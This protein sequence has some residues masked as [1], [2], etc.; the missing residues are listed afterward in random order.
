MT[1]Y[2]EIFTWKVDLCIFSLNSLVKKKDY[3]S[4]FHVKISVCIFF[5][6]GCGG[7]KPI[8]SSDQT[9]NFV[10]SGYKADGNA[11]LGKQIYKKI[12]N[13]SKTKKLLDTV[14]TDK[15]LRKIYG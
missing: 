4:N 11:A 15:N 7:Y 3:K 6:N 2:A 5:L 1:F 12:N 14:K 9:V 8:F 10:V 13:L